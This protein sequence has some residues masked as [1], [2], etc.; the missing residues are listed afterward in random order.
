M[1]LILEDDYTCRHGFEEIMK[2]LDI[3]FVSYKNN[4]E[5]SFDLQEN[6]LQNIDTA[7]IDLGGCNGVD[8]TFK[9]RVRFPEIFIIMISGY[10]VPDIASSIVNIFLHKPFVIEKKLIPI[11]KNRYPKIMA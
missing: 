11:L 10:D 5:L 8:M 3:S 4:D 7:M 2:Q 9:L 6:N 1:L